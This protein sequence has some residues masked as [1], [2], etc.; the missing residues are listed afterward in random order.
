VDHDDDGS[1]R[2][3]GRGRGDGAGT[4]ARRAAPATDR[5]TLGL[6]DQQKAVWDAAFSTMRATANRPRPGEGHTVEIDFVRPETPTRR[7]S[8]RR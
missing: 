1:S 8:G 3:D 6:T 5:G 7:S 2:G 4:T